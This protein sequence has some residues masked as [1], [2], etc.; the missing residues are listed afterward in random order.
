MKKIL[1]VG[2]GNLATNLAL[3]INKK[4]Y[5]INQIYSPN[6]T[7]AK[8]LAKKIKSEWTSNPKEIKQADI[9]I[10]AIKDD[11]IKML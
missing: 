8:N 1:L 4:G 2:S 5:L 10:I 9:T 11:E 7:N 3:N 6:K